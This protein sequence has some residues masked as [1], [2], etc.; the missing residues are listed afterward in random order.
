MFFF[1]LLKNFSKFIDFL[2]RIVSILI[3]ITSF[4]SI[5]LILYKGGF[6][7][8]QETET[9]IKTFI[10]KLQTI[11]F[12]SIIL[13]LLFFIKNKE[14]RRV[15]IGEIIVIIL[16]SAFFVE[17]NF[18]RGYFF[19]LFKDWYQIIELSYIFILNIIV[20]LIELSKLNFRILQRFN[21]SF[22]FLASFLLLIIIGTLLLLLPSATTN[23]ISFT[24]AFF[25]ATSAVCVTGL[26]VV[27]TATTFTLFGK[28]VILSLI[29]AGGLGIMTFTTFFSLFFS[30]SSS[31][32]EQ[33]LVKDMVQSETLSEILK[34]LL[35]II[36][37]TFTIEAF[38]FIFIWY[39][40][41]PNL[42]FNIENIKFALFHSVSA[43]C[44]AGFSTKSAGLMDPIAQY[45]Y[46]LHIIIALL[47]IAGGI[48][49]PIL[50]NYYKLFKHILFNFFRVIR[51]KPYSHKPHIININS[52]LVI[53]TT[54]SLIFFGTFF[55]YIFESNNTFKGLTW[56]EKL[57]ESFFASVTARTAGFS[58]INYSQILPIT[59]LLTMF[60]M[61]IGASPSST[62][63]GIKTSTFALA[64]LNIFSLTK[65]KSRIEIWRREVAI[66]CI[67]KAFAII[68]LSLLVIGISIVLVSFFNPQLNFLNVIFECFSAFGTVGLS[69]GVTP[70]LSL[71]SKWVIIFTMFTGRVGMLTFFLAFMK[72]I[73]TDRYKYPSEEIIIN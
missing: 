32:K 61:W 36:L 33:L 56:Y 49:F 4:L 70:L 64:I 22:L 52:R 11:T 17:H 42:S 60:L 24:D 15:I 7:L 66:N 55:Y 27:D 23:G 13:R 25:T 72:K 10:Y 20:F 57:I 45:N 2:S 31:F 1:K 37:F 12:Y 50:L 5:G 40:L 59:A 51:G 48:G 38:G 53:I 44:N 62:G 16:F 68:Q 43:F 3:F 46:F 18:Y 41:D 30:S 14:R 8:A 29:Q 69:M 34:T 39:A 67:R 58:T 71:E 47:I 21:H 19:H 9:L 54:L 6:N 63:G 65:G 28:A 26:T 35:K 73:K